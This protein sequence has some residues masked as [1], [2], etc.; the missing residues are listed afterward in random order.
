MYLLAHFIVQ[1]IK[2]I[3]RVDPELWE[4]TIFVSKVAHLLWTRIFSEKPFMGFLAP[5]SLCKILKKSTEQI[6]NYED[7]LFLGQ[8][9]PS[10][11]QKKS[12]TH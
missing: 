10:H 7:P 1:N 5:F 11:Q 9:A 12:E 3:L 2:M 6:Q 4:C 8:F